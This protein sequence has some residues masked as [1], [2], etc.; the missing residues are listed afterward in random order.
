MNDRR[1]ALTQARRFRGCPPA[2]IRSIPGERE[3]IFLHDA[4]CPICRDSDANEASEWHALA[5]KVVGGHHPGAQ[6]PRKVFHAGDLAWVKPHLG[7]WVD[8]TYHN[9]PLVLVLDAQSRLF[10]EIQVA[11]VYHDPTMAGPGD[12]VLTDDRTG[13]GELFIEPWNR[14]LL[15]KSDLDHPVATLGEEICQAVVQLAEDGAR[16]PSWAM[17]PRPFKAEDPRRYFREI[18]IEVG[19][20]FAVRSV[21]P[22]PDA[23]AI[24][25]LFS[26]YDSPSGMIRALEGRFGAVRWPKAADDIQSVL[27][28]AEFDLST[29]PMA[30]DTGET[31]RFTGMV[32]IVENGEVTAVEPIAV[33]VY[34][35]HPDAREHTLS[36]Q[37][38]PLEP[39][40]FLCGAFFRLMMPD[41]ARIQSAASD[42]DPASGVF[43][44]RFP[45]APTGT[46]PLRV[47]LICRRKRGGP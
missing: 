43:S 4:R 34:H 40:L 20:V 29:L 2:A 39:E 12:L 18:E 44:V 25:G 33:R 3:R 46:P 21:S 5:R 23:M 7:R 31:D 35:A 24:D 17:R 11:Q 19:R 37:I 10:D 36:G 27:T 41:G 9:P 47:T 30:A 28:G 26:G 6:I 13:I 45:I 14:Y 16:Y 8:H 22:R 38:G 15:K 32:F 1:S 42:V